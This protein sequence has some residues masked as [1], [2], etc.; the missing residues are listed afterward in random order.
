VTVAKKSNKFELIRCA[1]GKMRTQ[2]QIDTK[3]NGER[4]L[5]LRYYAQ[6]VAHREELKEL[7]RDNREARKW[8]YLLR[9]DVNKAWH[10]VAELEAKLKAAEKE[11]EKLRKKKT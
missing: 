7:R 5:A 6:R 3:R 10:E 9:A 11:L 2:R 1:D 4:W 8:V